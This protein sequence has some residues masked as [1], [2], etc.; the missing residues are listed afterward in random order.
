MKKILK[1]GVGLF[2]FLLILGATAVLFF[3]RQLNPAPPE[4]QAFING[5]ILTMDA[6]STIAEAVY[7]EKDRIVAVGSNEEIKTYITGRTKVTDLQGATMMPGIVDAHSHFPGNGVDSFW[8]N[9]N[10]PPVGSVTTIEQALDLL[11]EK[12]KNTPKGEWIIAYG[13]D[14]TLLAEKRH[15]TRADLDSVSTEHPIYAM[16]VSGHMGVANSLALEMAGVTASTPDPEGGEFVRDEQSGEL[17]G[18]LKESAREVMNPYLFDFS[19]L[20][21]FRLL[22]AGVDAYARNG[23]TTAQSGLASPRIVQSMGQASRLGLIPLRLV[24][25]PEAEAGLAAVA[26]GAD[27]QTYESDKFTVGAFKL[28]AD[29]SIQ[30][31]T[32]YLTEPYYVPPPG[33][34]AYRGYPV[35]GYEELRDL[36]M[37]IQNNGYQAAVHANGDAAIDMALDAFA[38]AQAAN[39]REDAR[40]IL[41][42]AQMMRPD[43]LGRAAELGVTPTFFVAHT[44]YWGDRHREIF[45]GPERAAQI[46]PLNTA[47]A[48]GV[49]FTIHLDTPVVPMNPMLLAWTAVNRQTTGGETLGPAERIPV[50]AALRAIT[51]DAAWQMFLED[52]RGSIEPGKL[53][54]LI[55]LSDDPLDN[56]ETLREIQVM[57]TIVGGITLFERD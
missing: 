8:V 30:G 54:D 57:K 12:A 20:E 41:V 46:S 49:P 29:G 48:K 25:W 2:L 45:L 9:L 6:A 3:W 23:V 55:V 47:L 35:T 38:A 32:G 53:A 37:Q 1:W 15:L 36:V 24:V 40:P 13:Y 10:S 43:Q 27:W 42:H 7:V 21:M 17:T 33:Q 22:Q 31:Y 26:A 56:P 4:S 44:Y 28:F 14:D 11:R 50:M 5:Q 16:H 51:I 18:L 34:T 19:P 39:P 52:D